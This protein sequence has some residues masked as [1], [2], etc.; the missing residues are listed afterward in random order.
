[1]ILGDVIAEKVFLST[2]FE[3]VKLRY[4]SCYMRLIDIYVACLDNT[5]PFSADI[6]YQ[7]ERWNDKKTVKDFR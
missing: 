2:A 4:T 7:G 3:I 1:V 6:L 5:W